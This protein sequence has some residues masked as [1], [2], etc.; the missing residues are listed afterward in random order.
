MRKIKFRVW[1]NE[2]KR[3]Y[4]D[5]DRMMDVVNPTQLCE[6]DGS[7]TT[8][9]LTFLQFTGFKDN[10]GNDIYEGDIFGEMDGNKDRIGEYEFH[11]VISYDSELGCFVSELHNGGFMYLYE[12]L[13]KYHTSEIIGNIYEN[14][15]LIKK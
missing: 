7:C 9:K 4:I 12:F 1:D 2:E 15:E 3:M 14:P 5:D 8:N 10:Q 13:S 11:G 6:W